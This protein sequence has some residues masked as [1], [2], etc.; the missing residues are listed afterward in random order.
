MIE[1]PLES[2]VV[3]NIKTIPNM[4]NA[5]LLSSIV[6]CADDNLSCDLQGEAVVLNLGTGVY[7]GLNPL[8][9]RIWELIQKPMQVSDVLDELLKEYKVDARECQVDLLGFLNQLLDQD[10]LKLCDTQKQ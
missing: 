8:G 9:A 6:V 7:F 10:L 1:T 5:I 4:E 2:D 3:P